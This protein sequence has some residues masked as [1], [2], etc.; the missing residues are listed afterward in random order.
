MSSEVI[1]IDNVMS[2]LSSAEID[3]LPWLAKTAKELEKFRIRIGNSIDG[4]KNAGKAV[5][6]HRFAFLDVIEELE[7]K[8]D[9][10]LKQESRKHPAWHWLCR[11]K[12]IS[13]ETMGKVLG[14][15]QLWEPE[16]KTLNEDTG[17]LRYAHS[18]GALLMYCGLG[19]VPNGDGT[20]RAQ[21]P[22][23]GAT[24]DANYDVRS[25]IYWQIDLFKRQKNKYYQFYIQEKAKLHD[26]MAR[27]G[28]EVIPTPSAVQRKKLEG[29]E[30]EGT[31]WLGHL[32]NM[33][34]RAT[35]SLFMCHLWEVTRE[36]LGMEVP[37]PY[38]QAHLGHDMSGYISPWDMVD[39]T[40]I[41]AN[42]AELRRK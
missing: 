19:V 1:R 7:S 9:S 18:R 5:S 40:E 26:E 3:E 35:C 14:N 16:E 36:S 22:T 34:T 15:I 13:A 20:F 28:R 11:M 6:D 38:P 42:A 32:D 23:K 30:G 4:Q 25:M 21:K 29:K 27:R 37:L 10:L 8:A 17:K 24:R 39:M 12:G 31:I 2:D 33:A 41:E